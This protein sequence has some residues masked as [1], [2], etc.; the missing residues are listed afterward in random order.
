MQLIKR[1]KKMNIKIGKYIFQTF[2]IGKKDI[3]KNWEYFSRIRVFGKTIGAY[4]K[5]I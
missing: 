1:N 4:W 2:P 3:P 5:L